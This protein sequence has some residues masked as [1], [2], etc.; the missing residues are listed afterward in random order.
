MQCFFRPLSLTKNTEYRLTIRGINNAA[1]HTPIISPI[2]IPIR[3]IS[4]L[5][6][7]SDGHDPS[8]DIEYL[9]NT[10]EVHAT[11]EGFETHDGTIRAYFFAIGSCTKGNYH[12]TNNQF[13]PV[14]PPTATSF[15]IQGLHLVN[16]QRYCVKIKAENFAAVESDVVSSNG[17]IVDVT[18]PDLRHAM[19][20]DGQG[21]D[22]IDHQSDS[23]ELSSTWTGIQDHESGIQHFEVAVSRNRAGQ[24]D[25]TSFIDA[26]RNTYSTITALSL[27]NEVYYIIL[28]AINNAGLKS[29]LASDGVLIDPT[30]PT[31]GIVHDGI[32]EPDIR[33]QATTNKL[34][35]NWERIWDLESRVERF[36]WGIFGEEGL[37]QEFVDVGL[38][39]HVTSKKPLQLKHGNN[40]TIFLRVYNR[41]GVLKKISS[42]GVII[43][44]TP[45]VPSEIIPR[46]SP[47][48]WSFSE[49][50][51]T[52]YSSSASDIYVTW[53]NFEE[54]ESE[55][56]YYKWAIGTSKYGTQLQPLINIGLVTNANTS[57]NGLNIRPGIRY[58]VTVIGR[59]RVDLVS[60]NCSWPFLVDYSAP[61]TG[62]IRIKSPSGIRKD[63]FRSDKNIHVSWSGFEDRESGIEK[64]DISVVHNN[65]EISNYS[66]TSID[67]ELEI[68]IDTGF[69]SPRNDYRIVVKSINYAGL[70]SFVISTPF[71]IDNTPPAY[72]GNA[73]DLPKRYFLSDPNLLEVA[74][75]AF[76]DHESPVEFYEIGIG[77]QESGDDI[78][79]FT[80]TGLR[81]HFSFRSLE[82]T[83][84]QTFYV[85]VNAYNMA[86]LETSLSLEEITFD[87]SPPTG[88]N[89]SVRDGL[90][91]EDI[92]YLSSGNTVS[93]TLQGI[94]DLESG[95]SK[96]EYCV[97]STP[98]NCF[99]KPFTSL[100][101]N[102]SFVCTDCKIDHGMTAFATFRVTNGAGLSTIFVSD[103]V[104]VDPT[105]P[106]IQFVYDGKKADYPDVEKTYSNWTPTVTWHGARD[107]QSGL[108]NC[109]WMI[110]KKDGNTT[111]SVY[112]KTLHKAEIT[113]NIRHTE[114][115]TDPLTLTTN[116]S[117]FNV[118]QCW[119]HAGI[120]IDQYSNGWSV[121]EQWPIPSYIIDGPGPH[122]M[123]YD[124]N[125]ENLHASWG[126]FHADSKDPII[127]YE[128]AVGTFGQVDDTLEFTDVE[129]DTKVS[130]SLSES[131]IILKT[132]V[133]YYI[134]VR[135]TT[136]S[137]WNSNKTSNGFIVDTTS[138]TAGI[139]KVD[140][141]ILNQYT[142]EVEYRISWEGFADSETGIANYAYCLGYIYDVCSTTVFNAGLAFQGTVRSFLPEVQD[143]SFYGIVIVTNAAGLKTIV[144]SN[145]VK[146]DF[147]PP[148]T[149][150]VLDG[151]DIDLDYINSS[152][153]L[154]TTWSAFTDPETGIE[155][156][157][158]TVN[159]ENPIKNE[160]ITMKVRV[161]VN[162]TGSIIHDF[163]MISGLQYVSTITCENFD[164]FKS[165]E[166]SNGVIVD[167]SPPI[168]GT[169]LDK[170]AQPFENQYQ[171]STSELHVR[172]T[173]GYDLESGIM[174]YLIAVGSGSNEDDI[175][176]FF[177]IGLAR[178]INIK[179]LTMTSGST[180]YITLQIV[181]KAGVTSR[182]SSTGITVDTTPPE[183]KEVCL[184]IY[185]YYYIYITLGTDIA[186]HWVNLK[187]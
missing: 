96:I 140:H 98:F 26:S 17:F 153:T 29:C 54:L 1:L 170:N 178:E 103:G 136:L 116:S 79:K 90:L 36:E 117:Y 50:T 132:G 87:Q 138:P 45:P 187:N 34:S 182:V 59:N 31:S 135:G 121:V 152:V 3:A 120:T 124:V 110:V 77:R 162:T 183:I 158:L 101:Q 12:V 89:G 20:F 97:G 143:N 127:K 125:G 146:I 27:N 104:T 6:T 44:T 83:D 122:D 147:T 118:I 58:F 131:D 115:A 63:Y 95:I 61:R 165:S 130:L 57:G 166:S 81:T 142:N 84:N 40:Y 51:A 67:A 175:R 163:V 28:C 33:Y 112:V 160:S 167:D 14:T 174:E 86:G 128:W 151:V 21:E 13:M 85:T 149:G 137:G 48:E 62:N 39:T 30:S 2:I 9:T 11:W 145:A 105:P 100:N 64:Y 22:D 80:K 71:I 157:T 156:C 176:E 126:A 180:Y 76:E 37:V 179:N 82:I 49:Q 41:A 78:F 155:K 172:W 66:R 168:P 92:D 68:L 46:L 106:E 113:Y 38:Q 109:Q 8:T 7:V 94:E 144:S 88:Y 102:M 119:N 56:W 169:I 35:G 107:V 114:R 19:V 186:I 25:V 69:L 133:E 93:A 181:N 16:G 23:A 177:S 141:H 139:V 65:R 154:A 134:T 185:I 74:W 42:N 5:G 70:E 4:G 111:I 184:S 60:G 55:I 99:I 171:S 159:E 148:V 91:R 164:G 161:D 72:T 32:L 75:A 47:L 73:N 129:L 10:S 24:P 43:D 52:Y 53:K 150:S 173:D 18:P 15:G 123:K 108:R